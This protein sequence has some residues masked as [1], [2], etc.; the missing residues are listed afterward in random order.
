MTE[1]SPSS[2]FTPE[3]AQR[4]V[5]E[6][7]PPLLARAAANLGLEVDGV[8]ARPEPN[9]RA[10]R[11]ALLSAAEVLDQLGATAGDDVAVPLRAAL[12][13]LE[14]L[15]EREHPGLPLAMP[16]HPPA[17]NLEELVANAWADA[18]E[19]EDAASAPAAGLPTPGLPAR[20]SILDLPD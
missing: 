20:G 14:Q 8:P 2:G 9:A 17:R 5:A 13:R 18:A 11:V 16:K 1:S 12:G 10:A 19:E 3:R 6:V 7:V 4:Y 15:F